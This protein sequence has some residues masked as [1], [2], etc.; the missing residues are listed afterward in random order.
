MLKRLFIFVA[1]TFFLSVFSYSQ[2]NIAVGEW[3]I[4]SNYSAG[5]D[6]D[7]IDNNLFYASKSGIMRI[8]LQKKSMY[9]ITKVEGLSDIGI[10]CVRA[11]QNTKMLVIAYSNA[12]IDIY[13]NGRIFNIPDIYNRQMPGDKTIY[14]IF[15]HDTSAYLACGF[16]AVVLNLKKK[17][18]SDSWIFRQNNLDYPVK[19]ILITQDGTI[20]AAT[21][22]A[23]LKNKITNSKIKDFATWEK[24]NNIN[25]PNN[26]CFKQLANVNNRLFLLKTD[27]LRL[28]DTTITLINDSLLIYDTTITS[29]V[30]S[31]KVIYSYNNNIWQKDSSFTFDKQSDSTFTYSF[32]RSSLDKLIVG[33]NFGIKSFFVNA[34]DNNIQTD[35][36]FY[37]RWDIATAVYGMDNTLFAVTETEGLFRGNSGDQYYY[38]MQGP[39]HG[40]VSAM[41]WKNNKLAMTHNTAKDWILKWN[42]GYVSY[43]QNN[44]WF[45]TS[46]W[47]YVY[48]VLSLVIAPYDNSII[49]A[50]SLTEG[51]LE[52]KDNKI[53]TRHDDRNSI[54][55]RL[56]SGTVRV[57]SP[58]FDKQNNL[59]VGNWGSD[60]PLVVRT[61][62][63]KWKS[64]PIRFEGIQTVEKI[65]EDSRNVLWIICKNEAR[66]VLFNP[67]GTLDNPVN[68]QWANL[69]LSVPPEKGE[70]NFVHSI[71]EDK[72]GKIWLGTDK[73]LKYYSRSSIELIKDPTF[74]PEPVTIRWLSYDKTDT[75]YE[76]ILGSERI[77]CIK[78]DA[79]NRK[80]VGTENSG[81]YLLSADCKKEI[82]H[83]TTENSPLLSNTIHHIEIDGKTGEVYFG[84]EKGLVSF[85]YT[86]TDPKE[87]Y[88]E[89]KIFPNPV[90]ED[91]NGY[92]SIEGLKEKSEIKITDAYGGLVYRTV[93]NGGTAAWDGKRFDGQ[94]AATGVYFVFVS[95]EY[96]KERIAGKILFIK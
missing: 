60:Y 26:D 61:S 84:T 41:D 43:L 17:I 91:F 24:M 88:E 15:I 12:N 28:Y 53:I 31:K 86:A 72:E 33:C 73:G 29:K 94:K 20:Y 56:E 2:S 37:D 85:R 10:Q 30:A 6:V 35:N 55:V 11:S 18:I 13:Q 63:E 76:L 23:L 36:L 58:F 69:N 3:K 77:R 4:Y 82:F 39:T 22:H 44:F 75:L 74:L 65:F 48:D 79:G 38:N 87:Q 16:G 46:T 96:G 19:D 92:I 67:N 34:S 71:A 49:F 21:D 89:L 81:V 9:P 59:W 57:T 93:S 42:Y 1:T 7:R 8:D 64:F 95:D 90:R 66:L 5:C 80:W 52:Y 40:A 32:I 47:D 70:M 83:F 54:L 51:L 14:S 25:T 68:H 62:D 78:I 50:A 45:T 27:T